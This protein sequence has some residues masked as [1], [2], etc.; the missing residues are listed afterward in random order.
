VEYRVP[1]ATYLAWLDCRAL[2]LA[3]EPVEVFR[4]AG[5]ELSAGTDFSAAA[6]GFVRLNFATSASMLEQIVA[7]MGAAVG[8]R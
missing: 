4:K 3:E 1:R 7:R 6:H 5:V 8:S 2:D